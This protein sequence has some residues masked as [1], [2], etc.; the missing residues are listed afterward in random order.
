MKTS[1]WPGF[2]LLALGCAA[3]A[4]AQEPDLPRP[5]AVVAAEITGQAFAVIDG[6]RKPLNADERVRVGATVATERRS[7]LTLQLSNGASVQ[8]GSETELEI[9]EFGQQPV[10]GGVGKFS[11]LKAE[12]TLSR[13]RLKLLKGDVTLDVKPLRVARGSSFTVVLPAGVLRTG[14]GALRASAMMSDYGLGI[15]TLE[16]QRGAAE[17]ELAG[18]AAA[19]VPVGTK[20]A[21][22]LE[23]DKA[24]GVVKVGEMP[25]APAAARK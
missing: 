9:E 17:L 6:Q 24:T 19:P 12:P 1:R 22:A 3:A 5:G 21:F 23:L 15:C 25:K 18:G 20:L 13:T 8:L 16:L 7:M 11:E 4:T 2:V 10:P 14:E